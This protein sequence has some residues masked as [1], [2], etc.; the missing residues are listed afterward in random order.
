MHLSLFFPAYN[1]EANIASS[2][3]EARKVLDALIAKGRLKDYEIIVVDDGSHDR[4]A[5]IVDEHSRMDNKVRLISHTT[6]R[7]YGAALWSGI[8]HSRFEWVF[9]TDAD[10]QF[11]LSELGRLLALVPENKVVIG[12]RA[13]RRDSFMRLINGYGWNI[14]N[15]ILFDL[16]VRDIDCAFKLFQR[17]L[18]A[19]LPLQTRGAAM[20]AEM[21]V[22]IERGGVVWKEVPVTHKPRTAGSPTGAKPAV[23]I[24]AFKEIFWLYRGE[25]GNKHSTPIQMVKYGM[26]GVVNTCVDVIAYFLLTR[27]IPF[28]GSH[29]LAA[30]FLTFFLGSFTS[31]FFN[32]YFTFGVKTPLRS[33]E[34][35]KFYTTVAF[36]ITVNVFMLYVFNSLL[37]IYDLI[38]VGLATLVTFIAGF[39][40]SRLW[41]FKREK[42]LD[43]TRSPAVQQPRP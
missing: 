20:S 5:A 10:L 8:T 33:S 9:F 6:N 29:I 1:E 37:G 28:F 32:R 21:L 30:K 23:I 31:F 35:V 26:V 22:R 42:S 27:F 34:F 19:N 38:A 3:G 13:P 17:D 7:G 12:Y 36:T 4:T 14:L 25:L 2:I 15:R 41:V 43:V 18:V 40:I 11:D 24:R 39:T 16:K